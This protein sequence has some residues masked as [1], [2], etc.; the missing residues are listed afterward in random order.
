MIFDDF[1]EIQQ[2]LEKAR[3]DEDIKILEDQIEIFKNKPATR[4]ILEHKLEELV[5]MK[6]RL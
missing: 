2:N 3:L 6:L 1:G 5:I 4:R